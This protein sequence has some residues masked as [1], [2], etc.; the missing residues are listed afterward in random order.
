MSAVYNTFHSLPPGLTTGQYTGPL[1]GLKHAAHWAW[2]GQL[3]FKQEI[4]IEMKIN[5][6]KHTFCVLLVLGSIKRSCHPFELS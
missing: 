1:L 2:T 3:R 6:E 5:W 4:I